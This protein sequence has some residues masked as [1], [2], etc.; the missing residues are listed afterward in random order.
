MNIILCQEIEKLGKVGQVLRVKDGY[1]RNFLFPRKLAIP[2]TRANQ[3]FV[4]E[5]KVRAERRRD[6]EKAE[7]VA[8]SEKLSSVKISLSVQAGEQDKLYGSVTTEDIAAALA[9]KGYAIQKKQVLLKEPIRTLGS[10]PVAVELYSQVKATVTV[11]V[12]RKP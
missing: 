8:V 2:S 11:E 3:Q 10:H 6:K 12:V 1:A 7:A 9:Q 4:E 5:Q